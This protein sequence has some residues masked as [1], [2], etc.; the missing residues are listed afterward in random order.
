[1]NR[2]A[3]T[4]SRRPHIFSVIPLKMNLRE[5]ILA[6]QIDEDWYKNVKNNIRQDTMMVPMYEGYSLEND[7]L[8]R[9]NRRIY[10][11]PNDKL[12]SLILSEAHRAMYMAHSG[13]TNM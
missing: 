7:G 9:F 1:V 10:V 8:L 12:R 13:V 4:L 11:S 5:N 6:L 2:V 3:Y